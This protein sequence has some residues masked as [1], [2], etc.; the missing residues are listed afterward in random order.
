MGYKVG[1]GL[2]KV[3]Q[4][5]S[6]F[7]APVEVPPIAKKRGLGH[8][9]PAAYFTNETWDFSQEH[10]V[11]EEKVDWLNNANS[12][13]IS[14]SDL[15]SWLKEGPSSTEVIKNSP[16]CDAAVIENVF[17]AKVRPIILLH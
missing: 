12:T 15:E 4:G 7:Q 11:V 5:P 3:E 8:S 2:G 17:N 6:S 14:P 9:A 16:F 1:S 13:E 10:L